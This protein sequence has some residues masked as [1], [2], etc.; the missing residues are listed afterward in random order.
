MSERPFFFQVFSSSRV[1]ETLGQIGVS[2][3]RD[4]PNIGMH[5]KH[6]SSTMI[7]FSR[8]PALALSSRDFLEHLINMS[9]VYVNDIHF[10]FHTTVLLEFLSLNKWLG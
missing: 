9:A 1:R 5:I 8:N 7:L 3:R 4:E 2:R 10:T 6:Q